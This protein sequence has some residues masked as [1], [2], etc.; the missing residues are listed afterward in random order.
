[1]AA[2]SVPARIERR[3]LRLIAAE[4]EARGYAVRIEP[5]SKQLPPPLK[6]IH[7]DLVA[8]SSK[9]NI[10]VEVK[11]GVPSED[12]EQQAARLVEA[13]KRLPNWTL[14]FRFIDT[15][16]FSVP[17]RRQDLPSLR[18]TRE[19]VAEYQ[20]N[21]LLLKSMRGPAQKSRFLY[22][23]AIIE[24]ALRQVAAQPGETDLARTGAIEIVDY[25]VSVGLL[26]PDEQA[27]CERIWLARNRLM[28]GSLDE[29]LPLEEVNNV[30]AVLAL[31]L[32]GRPRR[33]ATK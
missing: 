16:A 32:P 20:N 2:R 27:L 30:L 9:G 17:V 19:A 33:K 13:I 4:Y 7:P 10:L 29:P 12:T 11:A 3:L 8:T 5:G 24:A 31:R 1:M 22:G 15:D 18:E 6:G 25:L 28:H 21:S 26:G 14:E 23:T